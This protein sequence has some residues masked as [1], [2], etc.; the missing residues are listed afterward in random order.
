[1]WR[2]NT[3]D[4]HAKMP[5]EKWHFVTPVGLTERQPFSSPFLSRRQFFL[6]LRH[7]SRNAYL[8][9]WHWTRPMLNWCS[10]DARLDRV[11]TSRTDSLLPRVLVLPRDKTAQKYLSAQRVSE[12]ETM[13]GMTNEK[14]TLAVVRSKEN[15]ITGWRNRDTL[16][17]GHSFRKC[18]KWGLEGEFEHAFHACFQRHFEKFATYSCFHYGRLTWSIHAGRE[19]EKGFYLICRTDVAHGHLVAALKILDLQSYS[20]WPDALFLRVR[21]FRNCGGLFSSRAQ[22]ILTMT[23]TTTVLASSASPL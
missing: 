2:L 11:C 12:A 7:I 9:Q 6:H 8:L 1:M 13:S 22:G 3:R 15:R 4:Y 21:L 18:D 23:T 5:L 16:Y 19:S 20:V 10:N 17:I 14:G